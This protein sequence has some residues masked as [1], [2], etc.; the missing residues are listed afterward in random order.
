[1]KQILLP[2]AA[3]L[4]LANCAG[5]R[6]QPAVT[7]APGHGAITITIVPNPI[8]A[9]KASGSEYDFP[10]EVVIRETGGRPVEVDRVNAEVFFGGGLSLANETYDAA[11]IRGLGFQTTIPANGELRYRFSPRREVPDDR[12]FSSV[13]AELRVDGRDDTGTAASASTRVTVTR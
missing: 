4:V 2:I 8:R 6:S 13:S 11:R 1:M 5:N 3:L 12:L 9:T 7:A 10:F